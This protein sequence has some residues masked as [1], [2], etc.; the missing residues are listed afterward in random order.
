M[1]RSLKVV[2]L[3]DLHCDATKRWEESF[4]AVPRTSSVPAFPRSSVPQA[5]KW[6]LGMADTSLAANEFCA[7]CQKSS[8]A[9]SVARESAKALAT[10]LE[11]AA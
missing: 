5:P 6:G 10:M 2:H 1:H 7:D 3:S 11:G 9:P 4:S 8:H